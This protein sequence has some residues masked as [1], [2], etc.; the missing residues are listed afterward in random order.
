M[1]G[2]AA[3][4]AASFLLMRDNSRSLSS[5]LGL[6][7]KSIEELTV[8]YRELNEEQRLQMQAEL[9]TSLSNNTNAFESAI[10]DVKNELSSIGNRTARK[11]VPTGMGTS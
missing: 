10:R 2:M 5:E 9:K 3:T 1:I 8:K 7:G 4:V 6:Q 11:S